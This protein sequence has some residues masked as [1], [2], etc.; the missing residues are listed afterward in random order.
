MTREAGLR[1]FSWINDQV[2]RDAALRMKTSGI[3]TGLTS[4][5]RR[6]G[7]GRPQ[8][9]MRGGDEIAHHLLVAIRA[10]LGTDKLR[11][12]NTGRSHDRAIAVERA[13][14]KQRYCDK[15]CSSAAP[16]QSQTV[17]I[18]PLSQ[19]ELPTHLRSVLRE[20]MTSGNKFL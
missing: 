7:T 16:K 10:F 6:V 18:D 5:V 17:S 11:T 8:P 19:S 13:A 15:V 12:R 2:R 20:V 1:R 4:D 9:R 3:V 14:G